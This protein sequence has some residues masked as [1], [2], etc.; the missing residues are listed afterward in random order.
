MP[1]KNKLNWERLDAWADTS[2]ASGAHA[3]LV[4][5]AFDRLKPLFTD[6]W[7][8]KAVNTTTPPEIVSWMAGSTGMSPHRGDLLEFALRLELLA[9]TKR[10]LRLR[11][12]L[13]QDGTTS[14]FAGVHRQMTLA[15]L[16]LRNGWP[17]EFEV[18]GST[19]ADVLVGHPAGDLLFESTV[20]RPAESELT[21]R[22]EF[23]NLRIALSDAGASRGVGVVGRV[24]RV[25]SVDELRIVLDAIERAPIG[26]TIEFQ[27]T[28]RLKIVSQPE[29][30]KITTPVPSV[31]R[32]LRLLDP[33]KDKRKQVAKSGAGWID[34]ELRTSLWEDTPLAAA[35][36]RCR[37]EAVAA[38]LRSVTGSDPGLDGVVLSSSTRLF[39]RPVGEDR[40]QLSDGSRALRHSLELARGREVLIVVL[41]DRGRAQARLVEAL[42]KADQGWFDV[43]AR[44]RR[45]GPRCLEEVRQPAVDA[46]RRD[47]RR[48]QRPGPRRTRSSRR[49]PPG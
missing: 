8:L 16:A 49:T 34:I 1:R 28:V 42:W 44:R 33:L 39:P 19:P 22:A 41:S 47:A 37:L 21:E 25:L 20:R 2:S 32:W 45:L 23:A 46:R 27:S 5:R 26:R 40:A 7:L 35:P 15:G 14:G 9:G 6:Q 4:H 11:T 38:N 29:E 17:V 10:M 36:L 30:S 18:G 12:Q 31:D 24:D 48:R 3:E 13:R 43:G